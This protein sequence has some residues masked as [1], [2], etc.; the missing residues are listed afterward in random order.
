MLQ[1]ILVE[2]N[3]RK[4][5][6]F[7]PSPL[8][9]HSGLQTNFIEIMKPSRFYSLSIVLLWMSRRL[10]LSESDDY[11]WAFP[12]PPRSHDAKTAQIKWA[13]SLAVS[14]PLTEVQPM[15][16]HANPLPTGLKAHQRQDFIKGSNFHGPSQ[17]KGSLSVRLL[18]A[19]W[20]NLRQGAWKTEARFSHK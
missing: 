2:E 17:G 4:H 20:F 16:Q 10:H 15:G 3:H 7:I 9:I 14:C 6:P 18:R 19:N 13:L 5:M 11:H 8:S 1:S 12:P